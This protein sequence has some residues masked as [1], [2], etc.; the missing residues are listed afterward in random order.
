VGAR[1]L[2]VEDNEANLYLMTYLLESFGHHTLV[3]RD[4]LAGLSIALNTPLDL[5]ICDIQLPNIGGYGVAR[6]IRRLPALARLPLVAVTALAMVGDQEKVLAAGFDGYIAKPI[7]PE[8][9]VGQVD[10][11]LAPALRSSS[12]RAEAAPAHPRVTP[13]PALT[14]AHILAVD[15]LAANLAVL[16]GILEPFGYRVSTAGNIR[17]AIRRARDGRPDLIIADLHMPEGSGY[18]LLAALKADPLLAAIP[19]VFISSTE[20]R[21]TERAQ[22]LAHGARKFL[23]RPIEPETLLMEIEE[24]LRDARARPRP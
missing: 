24:C 20:Q 23:L 1:I 17:D 16:Q 8:A 14:P 2:V 6:E 19:F 11:F 9:F 3:A 22:G 5:I 13:S 12:A 15:D 21:Q 10:A 7:A 18:D 4:G